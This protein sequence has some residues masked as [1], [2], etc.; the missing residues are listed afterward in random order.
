MYEALYVC[1]HYGIRG[2]GREK[3]A[4]IGQ[5]I[6]KEKCFLQLQDLASPRS[7]SECLLAVSSSGRTQ[8]GKEEAMEK[9]AKREE[10]ER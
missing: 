1:S 2:K 9:K 8:R 5:L 3:G 10:K 6:E 7:R 4:E